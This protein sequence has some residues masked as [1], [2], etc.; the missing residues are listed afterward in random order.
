MLIVTKVRKAY[1]NHPLSLK[2]TV[3][4]EKMFA[5]YEKKSNTKKANVAEAFKAMRKM[6]K[7]REKEI[8][9]KLLDVDER[10]KRNIN[11]YER[12]ILS[13][14]RNLRTQRMLFNTT[15]EERD[16]VQVLRDYST[17]EEY[18]SEADREWAKLKPPAIIE[19]NIE[20]I[21]ECRIVL[22]QSIEKIRIAELPPYENAR[23]AQ[24]IVQQ[25]KDSTLNLNNQGLND[26]DMII[27]AQTIRINQVRSVIRDSQ[28][29][30]N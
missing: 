8:N 1:K 17:H 7:D 23:L 5:E 10:N 4:V 26:F 29:Y 14:W 20:G 21:E 13:Q 22:Q 30:T 28:L 2:P 12:R 19:Y 3:E 24:I 15:V 18:L 25:E 9:E 27:V 6:I 16:Y 11:D